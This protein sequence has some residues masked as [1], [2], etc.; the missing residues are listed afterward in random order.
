MYVFL[1]PPKMQKYFHLNHREIKVH[2]L[3]LRK[4]VIEM[5]YISLFI[6]LRKKKI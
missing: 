4:Q 5:Y 6:D 2:F 1:W 3:G